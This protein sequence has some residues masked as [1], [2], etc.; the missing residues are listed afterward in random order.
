MISKRNSDEHLLP[1]NTASIFDD[2]WVPT[3]T[4]HRRDGARIVT[5]AIEGPFYIK[6]GGSCA[7]EVVSR[8]LDC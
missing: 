8:I 2:S 6:F 7:A 3:L 4:G 5:L 1:L